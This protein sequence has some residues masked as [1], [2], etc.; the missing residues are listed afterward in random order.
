MVQ[1]HAL[2]KIF[3]SSNTTFCS[4]FYCPSLSSRLL[5]PSLVSRDTNKKKFQKL[6]KSSTTA[7]RSGEIAQSPLEIDEKI[8]CPAEA[9]VDAAP[10]SYRGVDRSE[11]PKVTQYSCLIYRQWGRGGICIENGVYAGVTSET[12]FHRLSTRCIGE[13]TWYI[14]A[15]ANFLRQITGLN[16]S[17]FT[18][19]LLS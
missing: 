13:W 15:S 16:K 14:E 3:I 9:R 7:E 18:V 11:N 2:R 17:W 1:E 12:Y 10:C 19:V 6:S 5:P 8:S 4:F